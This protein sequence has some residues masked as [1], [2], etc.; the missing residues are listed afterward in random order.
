MQWRE[1]LIHTFLSSCDG[2]DIHKRV[3]ASNRESQ[4]DLIDSTLEILDSESGGG[5]PARWT[6]QYLQELLLVDT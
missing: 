3:S 5:G 4:L 2:Y 1:E 6:L